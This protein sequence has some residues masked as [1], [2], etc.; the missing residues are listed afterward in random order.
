MGVKSGQMLDLFRIAKTD[1]RGATLTES[2]TSS[3]ALD[4]PPRGWERRSAVIQMGL[5]MFERPDQAIATARR[6]PVIGGFLAHVRL[7]ADRG[8]ATADTGPPGHLTVWGHPLQFMNAVVDISS[9][10]EY[11]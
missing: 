6:F 10:D 11:A 8:F 2:F 7:A 9:V 3:F 4:R 1:R 5:S